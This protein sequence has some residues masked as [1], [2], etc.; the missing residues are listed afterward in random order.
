ME[1]IP[2]PVGKETPT[3]DWRENLSHVAK[4][5]GTHQ[6]TQH[7]LSSCCWWRY[8]KLTHLRLL[9][10]CSR[11]S[12][13]CHCPISQP[14]WSA[15][16][17]AQAHTA[18][19][20]EVLGLHSVAAVGQQMIPGTAQCQSAVGRFDQRILRQMRCQLNFT[21]QDWQKKFTPGPCDVWAKCLYSYTMN[22]KPTFAWTTWTT[23]SVRN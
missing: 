4:W 14:S 3:P 18:A 17:Q 11:E 21:N 2:N 9:W 7:K 6:Q 15:E 5:A 16:E 8:N 13:L 23:V 12:W 19:S 20:A 22:P 1:E 10:L